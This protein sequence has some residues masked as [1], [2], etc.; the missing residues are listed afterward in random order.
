MA[1]QAKVVVVR[2]I[3]VLAAVDR[4]RVARQAVMDAE[5]G[6]LEGK[7]LGRTQ[8][9]HRHRMVVEQIVRLRNRVRPR[10]ATG[11]SARA[12]TQQTLRKLPFLLRRQARDRLTYVHYGTCPL[13]AS[14]DPLSSSRPITSSSISAGS[15]SI[16]LTFDGTP[17]E[18]VPA[19]STPS[20]PATFCTSCATVAT[21]ISSSG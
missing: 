7:G 21:S 2:E 12:L 4:R 10:G 5:I 1:G 6:I 8:D 9:A 17:S 14:A 13:A 20:F 16:S 3:D 11:A 19:G 15:V 18:G